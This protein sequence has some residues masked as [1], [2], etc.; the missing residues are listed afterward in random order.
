MTTE[1]YR[2][3]RGP[4]ASTLVIKRSRFVGAIAPVPDEPAARAFLHEI[5][6]QHGG[7]VHHVYAYV[8]RQGGASRHS[9]DGEPRG[10]GGLPVLEVLR[11]ENI[12]DAC[13]VVARY[14]GGI[15]LGAPGLARAYAAAAKAAL[16]DAGV[17]ER[18]AWTLVAMSFPYAA[19][20]QAQLEI[21]EAGGVVEE[22]VFAA[23]V[24]CHLAI[25]ATALP[26]LA[27]R[28]AEITS[29]RAQI[30][31]KSETFL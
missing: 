31:I 28:I 12:F 13:C 27:N 19:W 17:A 24:T 21:A 22:A 8:L 29:G 30:R 9:D 6:T 10:T 20:R 18:R 15:L 5:R 3:P 16:D 25:P 23:E 11:R 2:T 7:A 4:G 26:A 1:A 14:F